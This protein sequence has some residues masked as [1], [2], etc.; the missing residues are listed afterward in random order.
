VK[1][2]EQGYLAEDIAIIDPYKLLVLMP[3]NQLLRM[4]WRQQFVSYFSNW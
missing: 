1:D 4:N 3:S 2:E